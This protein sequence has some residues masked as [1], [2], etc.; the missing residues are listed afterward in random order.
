MNSRGGVSP[1][2]ERIVDFDDP[3]AVV[4]SV[5]N[6]YFAKRASQ[7]RPDFPQRHLRFREN[8]FCLFP[9]TLQ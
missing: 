2:A 1:Q 7:C 5:M 9:N 4:A 8:A 3:N 6:G